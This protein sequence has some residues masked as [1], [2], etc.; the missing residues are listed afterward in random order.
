MLGRREERCTRLQWLEK[1]LKSDPSR[2]SLVGAE[3][4]K[5]ANEIQGD[6][7]ALTVGVCVHSAGP[8]CSEYGTETLGHNWAY[9][10]MMCEPKS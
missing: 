6:G 2:S 7:T 5:F 8:A 10:H 4:P 1:A 3:H 9:I